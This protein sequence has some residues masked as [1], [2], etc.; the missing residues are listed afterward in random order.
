M[1]TTPP[2]MAVIFCSPLAAHEAVGST[3]ASLLCTPDIHHVGSHRL[4]SPGPIRC[5]GRHRRL[6][7][8]PLMEPP[9]HC[10]LSS[11]Q[12]RQRTEAGVSAVILLFCMV[13]L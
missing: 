11:P 8:Y 3:T 4:V 10:T 1:D 2:S 12:V 6:R 13:L 9:N 7:P 5:H